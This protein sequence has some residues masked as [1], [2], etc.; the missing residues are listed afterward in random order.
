M[1]PQW[2]IDNYNRTRS[3]DRFAFVAALIFLGIAI[4]ALI[5]G[6]LVFIAIIQVLFC[7]FGWF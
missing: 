1:K 3:E 2:E 5:G 6:V 7:W 4:E